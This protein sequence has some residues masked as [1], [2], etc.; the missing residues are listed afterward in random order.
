[1]S[2]TDTVDIDLYTA[3]GQNVYNTVTGYSGTVLYVHI[4]FYSM[5]NWKLTAVQGGLLA[6]IATVTF[7]DLESH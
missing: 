2:E 6:F 4:T 1:M 7:T 3:E 5:T